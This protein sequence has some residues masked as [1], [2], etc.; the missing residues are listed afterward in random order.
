MKLEHKLNLAIKV[1]FRRK[2]GKI[3]CQMKKKPTNKTTKHPERDTKFKC[4]VGSFTWQKQTWNYT[5]REK[6]QAYSSEDLRNIS[7]F[8]GHTWN[9]TESWPH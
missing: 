5:E 9:R 8:I 1:Q 3:I 4:L 7:M 6:F 2:I